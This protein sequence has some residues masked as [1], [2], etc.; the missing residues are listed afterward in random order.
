MSKNSIA[1]WKAGFLEDAEELH[2]ATKPVFASVIKAWAEDKAVKE[3]FEQ[4]TPG[5]KKRFD[6]LKSN[7]TKAW[8]FH[9]RK[10]EKRKC[11]IAKVE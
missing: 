9:E 6:C 5:G 3:K 10:V 7:V 1:E 2:L 11:G 4:Y 8:E